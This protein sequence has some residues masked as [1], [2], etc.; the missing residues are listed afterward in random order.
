MFQH[1][2]RSR[3]NQGPFMPNNH[4]FQQQHFHQHQYPLNGFQQTPLYQHTHQQPTQYEKMPNYKQKRPSFLKA[5]FLNENGSFDVGRTFETFNKVTKT[6]NQVTP[7]VKQVSPI[8]K[9]VSSLFAK[10]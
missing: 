9:Q 3:Y 10:K 6:V 8:V 4:M 5:A 7:I 2:K 1:R